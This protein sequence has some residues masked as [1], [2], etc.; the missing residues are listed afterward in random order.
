MS[1]TR[2][3]KGDGTLFKRA[4]GMWIGGLSFTGAD[5]KRRRKTVSS[6]D[7]NAAQ[8]KLRELR[9]QIDAGAVP[10]TSGTTVAKWLDHWLE[11][12]HG[13]HIRPTTVRSYELSIRQRIKPAI[14]TIRLDKLTAQN[15]R[16]MI[17]GIQ[18]G[19]DHT[20][21]A[22]PRKGRRADHPETVA[23][24]RT[25]SNTAVLKRST[26]EA[27]KADQVLR[28]ALKHAVRE[29]L[30]FRNPMD[31]VVKPGHAPAQRKAFTAD[32]A[33]HLIATA[34]SSG[35]E[36]WATRWAAAF[37]TGARRAELL[38][39][40]WDRV[41]LTEG[42][43]DLAWQLQRLSKEHGCGEAI[44]NGTPVIGTAANLYPCKHSRPSWCPQARWNLAPG[45]E[46]IECHGTLCW[47]RP[48]TKAGTRV[49]PLLP[50]MIAALERLKAA[51]GPNPSGLVFHHSDGRPI[52]PEEDHAAWKALLKLAEV[53][54]APL[55]AARHT[56][57]TLLQSAGVD[58]QTRMSLM[59]QSSVAA[60]RGYIHVDR[61]HAR[62]ALNNLAAL[63]PA[64][65]AS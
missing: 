34:V 45:F 28:L 65:E 63:L 22:P 16:Q 25:N 53:D 27:Q 2:R 36:M 30:L 15:V 50:P 57:A 60:H 19:P 11:T 52:S 55:H 40:T 12:I 58:E 32:I 20:K 33:R 51:E 1:P 10:T 29:G 46:M 59:G 44:T 23:G 18:T 54:D 41:D 47:T 62:K 7:R 56:T 9:K 43:V 38:G 3:T 21:T 17:V 64:T 14:G 5:G 39:L 49:V 37:L 61:T 35:D 4:D 48:K 31:A 24:L 6:K 8:T 42:F 13:P 26:R